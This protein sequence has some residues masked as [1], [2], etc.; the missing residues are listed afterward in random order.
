MS[1]VLAGNLL[2]WEA[3]GLYRKFVA[4]LA[5]AGLLAGDSALLHVDLPITALPQNMA[6]H[7]K[8]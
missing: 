7:S 8:Q 3:K 2:R 6:A 4:G 1:W 5:L